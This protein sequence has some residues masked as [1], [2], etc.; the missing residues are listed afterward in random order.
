MAIPQERVRVTERAAVP[1][2]GEAFGVSWRGVWA[3]FLIALGTMLLLSTL[4]DG[5]G[6]SAV[7]A[8]AGA[9]SLGAG[10]AVWAW[11]TLLASVFIGAM[12]ATSLALVAD[13]ATA[14]IHGALV[15]VLSMLAAVYFAA[16][17]ISL[18]VNRLLGM[19]GGTARAGD[20]AEATSWTAFAAMLVSL[21]VAIGGAVLG[22]RRGAMR[23]ARV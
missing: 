23:V 1:A 11:I 9:R 5:L 10:A 16:S 2:V 7:D 12:V 15:W 6:V 18:G 14:A 19:T 8:G 13:D 21:L 3:G 17:G 22:A 20:A 4:G